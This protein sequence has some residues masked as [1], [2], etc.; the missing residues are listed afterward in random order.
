MSSN[1]RLGEIVQDIVEVRYICMWALF[2]WLTYPHC[3]KLFPDSSL[4]SAKVAVVSIAAWPFYSVPLR[5]KSVSTVLYP[6][7][8]QLKAAVNPL[9]THSPEDPF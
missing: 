2:Q 5:E 8:T 9:H 7:I 4:E 3:E 1:V 6:P